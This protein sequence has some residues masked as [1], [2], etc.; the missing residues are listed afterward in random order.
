MQKD[1]SM[2]A[3]EGGVDEMTQIKILQILLIFLNPKTLRVSK[4]FV[5]LVILSFFNFSIDFV[6]HFQSFS[7]KVQCCKIYHTGYLKTA[8]LYNILSIYSE[9]QRAHLVKFFFARR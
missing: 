6:L 2:A 5:D 7:I 4:E 3:I 1:G 8:I 9:M